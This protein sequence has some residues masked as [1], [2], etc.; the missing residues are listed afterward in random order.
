MED[1]AEQL[2]IEDINEEEKLDDEIA[3]KSVLLYHVM[4]QTSKALKLCQKKRKFFGS[5]MHV[6]AERLLLF[7]CKYNP[8][9]FICLFTI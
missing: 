9:S 3:R 4:L 1:I 5:V 8:S 7:A 2:Q 6:E